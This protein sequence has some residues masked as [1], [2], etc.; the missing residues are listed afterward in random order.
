M[1]LFKNLDLYKVI[2]L[3]SDGEHNAGKLSPD[4]AIQIAEE[5]GVR[6]YSIGVGSSGPR[7]VRYVNANGKVGYRQVML[8]LDEETLQLSVLPPSTSPAVIEAFP[9]P[10]R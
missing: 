6:V 8:T 10:S 4:E 7:Y 3:L 2:I 5:F 9:A 1:N